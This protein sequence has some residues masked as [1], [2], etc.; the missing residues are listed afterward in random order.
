MQHKWVVLADLGSMKAY[1]VD[2]NKLNSHPRLEL[3]DSF[4]NPEVHTKLSQTLSDQAG[5]FARGS[6]G[7][8]AGHE[9]ASGERHNIELEQRRRWVRQLAERIQQ[10]LR[11]GD[12]DECWFAAGKEI[13]HQILAELPPELRAKIT[14]N[15]VANLTKIEKQDVLGHFQ[16]G[17]A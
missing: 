16:S 3:L 13:N 2:D 6:R 8:A 5:R 14:R 7:T 10:V 11:R 15:V 4:E 1:K 17:A 9:I 12:V